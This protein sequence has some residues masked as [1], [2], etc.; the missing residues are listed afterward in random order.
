MTVDDHRTARSDLDRA[1]ASLR[2][3][4]LDPAVARVAGDVAERFE[5]RALDAVHL[6]SALALGGRETV[7]MTWDR[8]LAAA[9][10]IAGLGIAP[11]DR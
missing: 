5:L 11:S 7:V 3:V 10:A 9:A 1:I 6:A 8:T 2:I 4:E